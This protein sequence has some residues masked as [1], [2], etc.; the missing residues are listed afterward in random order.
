M[1]LEGF[2]FGAI[3]RLNKKRIL[4]LSRCVW[5]DGRENLVMVGPPGVGKTLSGHRSGSEGVPPA[6]P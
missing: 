5:V 3:L 6:G 1:E 2:D 4:D